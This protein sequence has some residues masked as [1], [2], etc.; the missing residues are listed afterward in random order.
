MNPGECVLCKKAATE[1]CYDD[2]CREC[3]H[4][5]SLEDCKADKQVNAIRAAAGM[6][7]IDRG[8]I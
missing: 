4:A 7:P 8:D 5:E 2:V 6:R 3:H 1:R